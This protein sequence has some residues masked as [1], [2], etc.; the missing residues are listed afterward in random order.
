MMGPYAFAAAAVTAAVAVWIAFGEVFLTAA[1][2]LFAYGKFWLF[3]ALKKLGWASAWKFM[4]PLFIRLAA[5][6]LPKRLTFWFLTLVIG[7]RKRRRIQARLDAV[8]AQGHGWA[9]GRY[10]RLEARFGRWTK[11]LV[12]GALVLLSVLLSVF[13]LGAYVIWYS[14]SFFRA[15][16]L[17][18]R[19]A[20]NY[21]WSYVK[22]GVFNAAVLSPFRWMRRVLPAR[23]ADALRRFN[24]RVM[25]EVVRRR[26]TVRGIADS[27]LSAGQ[28]AMTLWLPLVRGAE[29]LAGQRRKPGAETQADPPAE[30]A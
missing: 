6:E 10:D 25:R 19:L 11:P 18:G 14:A 4:Q 8:K 1:S 5:W 29:A 23:Q 16:L 30:G 22:I 20:L 12:G 28:V 21:A 27:R 3:A 2:V 17:V 24:F 26:R 9:R 15:L 13:V 7:A